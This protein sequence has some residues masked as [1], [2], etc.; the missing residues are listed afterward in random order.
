MKKVLNGKMYDTDTATLMAVWRNMGDTRNFSYCEE[1]LY[2]KRT[3]EYFLYGYGGPMTKYAVSTG[4]NSWSGGEM[5]I[6]LTLSAA[7]EWAE[8]HLD[9]DDYQKIF[10]EVAE[11]DSRTVL[12]VSLPASVASRIRMMAS[13]KGISVS[14]LIA[15]TFA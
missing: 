6:P 8:E 12:S 15:E 4:S 1:T 10:G 2:R 7:Q 11:D 14:A 13:E 5:I 3:G 9:G